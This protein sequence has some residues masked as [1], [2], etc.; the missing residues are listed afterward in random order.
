M[1]EDEFAVGDEQLINLTI[2]LNDE[3]K[4]NDVQNQ[5]LGFTIKLDWSQAQPQPQA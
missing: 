3:H 5:S 4:Q 1:I 2:G